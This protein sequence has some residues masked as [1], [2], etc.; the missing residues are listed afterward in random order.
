MTT[1]T[2]AA[3]VARQCEARMDVQVEVD[4][5]QELVQRITACAQRVASPVFGDLLWD[6]PPDLVAL[7]DN[8]GVMFESPRRVVVFQEIGGELRYYAGGW[9]PD[10]GRIHLEQDRVWAEGSELGIFPTVRDAL[11]F[12]EQYLVAGPDF[13]AI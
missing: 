10:Q 3:D 11:T 12:A 6:V 7:F 5:E 9:C 1:L 4:A 13:Q 2:T 8:P